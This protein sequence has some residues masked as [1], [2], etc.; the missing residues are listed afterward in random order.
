MLMGMAVST[1][2]AS[3]LGILATFVIDDFAISREQLG[4]V[5]TAIIVGAGLLSPYAGRVTDRIGGKSA[6]QGLVVAS[7]ASFLFMAVAPVYAAMF[8]GAACGAVAQAGGNPATNKLIALHVP[9]GRRG[10]VTGIKQSGVQL[11]IFLGGLFLPVGAEM[12]GWRW[13]LGI[14]ALIAVVLLA[15]ASLLVPRDRPDPATAGAAGNGPMPRS[16]YWLAVYG[17]LLGFGGSVTFFLALFVEESLGRSPR[18]GGLAVGVAGLTAILGRIAWARFAERQGRFVMPLGAIAVV[19]VIASASLLAATDTI[20]LLWIGVILT[21][22]S[23]SSW[24]SVGMLAV[25]SEAGMERAG[26]ASGIVMLG[27]LIGLGIGPPLFGRSID[28]T[29]SYD[30]MWIVSIGT[31]LVASLVALLWA[32]AAPHN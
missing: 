12:I 26:G 28:S 30:L 22:L 20:V 19:S 29:G 2:T 6:F 11:G 3:T 21:G 5:V 17:F 15:P 10:L 23:S 31:F 8:L 4:W 18:L 24:N 13:A 9:V 25:M 1:A 27:F 16:I 7:A 32:R 14:V